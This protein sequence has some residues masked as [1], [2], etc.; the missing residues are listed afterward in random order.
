MRI[1]DRIW[2]FDVIEPLAG[3][4]FAEGFHLAGRSQ[5]LL[6]RPIGRTVY[7]MPPYLIDAPMADWLA[8]RV[9]A[10][11]DAVTRQTHPDADRTPDAATA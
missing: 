4:R 9:L 6:I 1:R 5:E 10:T 11:L 2:A 3:A 7:L 8:Q